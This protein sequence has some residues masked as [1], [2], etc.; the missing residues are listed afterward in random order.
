MI[1]VVEPSVE[2]LTPVEEMLDFPLR[3]ERAG[4]T[5]YKS[6]DKISVG[7]AP[8]F[9]RMLIRRGHL[10]VLEHCSISVRF[11]CSR[12][13]SHQL[14]RHRIAAYSQESMRFCNYS[15]K[16]QVIC[17]P[18]LIEGN[19]QDDLYLESVHEAYLTYL[20][21]LRAGIKPQ[22]ARFVLPIGT[23]TEVVATYNLRQWRWVFEQ[24]ALNSH[25]QW[26]IRRLMREC[27]ERFAEHMPSIFGD[28]CTPA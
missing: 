3:I 12:A 18:T 6:E 2:I 28:M 14:V 21:L 10:S 17:P 1:E 8:A 15:G 23:K 16:L 27:L 24:R 19:R 20:A 5:C 25:A 13:C 22:D 4:R 7:S 26:E 9:C 11:V